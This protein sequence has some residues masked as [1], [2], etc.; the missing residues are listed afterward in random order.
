MGDI[1]DITASTQERTKSDREQFRKFYG[2]YQK[3]VAADPVLHSTLP[4]QIKITHTQINAKIQIQREKA[5]FIRGFSNWAFSISLT[6]RQKQIIWCPVA[7]TT[8]A[9]GFDDELILRA[10][11]RWNLEPMWNNTSKLLIRTWLLPSSKACSNSSQLRLR[12][13]TT[14]ETS[15]WS[16]QLAITGI[17]PSFS[18]PVGTSSFPENLGA[19]SAWPPKTRIINHCP[20]N[21][22][23]M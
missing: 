16:P 8:V 17:W 22:S 21:K 9:A 23:T 7:C 19:N 3:S 15:E 18:T 10:K 4:Y 11:M 2:T 1:N 14:S 6:E 20:K 5:L 13:W 12:L